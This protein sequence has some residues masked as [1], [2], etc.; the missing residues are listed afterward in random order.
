MK[1]IYTTK[2][3]KNA[4]PYV[5]SYYKKNWGFCLAENEKKKL[6]AG[7]YKVF[8]D[9]K[10]SKGHMH[11]SELVLKGKSKKE[12]FFSTYIC[13]PGMANNELSGPVVMSA[14]IKFIKENLKKR[15]YTYRF[16]F[17]PET[18]GAI[19][20]IK[21]NKNKLIKNVIAAY[22]L[23]CLGR[24]NFS[25]VTSRKENTLAD[26]SLE[27]LLLDK[28]YTKYS[29][30]DHRGSDERQYCWP[31]VDLPMVTFCKKKFD[32]YKE[33]HTSF[34]NIDFIREKDLA[35]SLNQLSILL[36]I[37]EIGI[38]PKTKTFCEPNLGKRNLYPLVSNSSTKELPH[39]SKDILNFL[40]YSDG[41]TNIFEIAI[42]IKLNLEKILVIYILMIDKKLVN[43][44]HLILN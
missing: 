32:T 4:I 34:D 27:A 17:N 37:Y 18:I 30:L 39:H 31:G 19:T 22:N 10:F 20:Y 12:I 8:I 29:F 13:H 43:N 33:Y 25:F 5:T 15:H 35:D 40:C 16:V 38:Y 24:G 44:N 23:S 41:K 14:L 7:K 36:K 42:K 2:K 21:N 6:P 1:K 3:I 26:V 11:M 28:K 9:T